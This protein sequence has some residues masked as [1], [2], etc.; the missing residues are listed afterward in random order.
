[1]NPSKFSEVQDYPEIVDFLEFHL[2][3]LFEDIKVLLRLPLNDLNAGCNFTT[4]AMLFN[5][6]AG[7]SVCFYDTSVDVL[8]NRSDRSKRFKN[9]LKDYYPWE[10]ERISPEEG[11]KLL[12]EQTRNPLAHSLGLDRPP[13]KLQRVKVIVLT[14]RPLTVEEISEL[15]VSLKRP[16]WLPQTIILGSQR[17]DISVTTLYWGVHRLLHNLFADQEQMEK[18]KKF[19]RTLSPT[20][21]F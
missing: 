1:M 16:T 8:K 10:G 9:L 19:L 13:Q 21:H 5:I 7:V 4:A 3:M 12:Y 20:Q 14:K 11:S 6:I 18:A 2:D 15:E 17:I